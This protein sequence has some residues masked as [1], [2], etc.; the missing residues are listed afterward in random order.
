MAGPVTPLQGPSPA[1]SRQG[2]LHQLAKLGTAAPTVWPSPSASTAPQPPVA[3]PSGRIMPTV[4]ELELEQQLQEERS[5]NAL[6]QTAGCQLM[7]LVHTATA[8][9]A[10]MNDSVLSQLM[11]DAQTLAASSYVDGWNAAYAFFVLA[12]GQ[13]QQQQTMSAPLGV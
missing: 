6:L 9:T 13:E 8:A 5:K 2:S 12:G 4:R 1:A 11:A 3:Q 10:A 7:Q